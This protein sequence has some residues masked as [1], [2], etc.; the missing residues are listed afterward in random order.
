[1]NKTIR[2]AALILLAVPTLAF[3]AKSDEPS[4][5]SAYAGKYSGTVTLIQSF[6]PTPVVGT[7]QGTFNASKKKE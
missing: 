4:A 5:I 2:R 6:S 3:A 1:M 7:A